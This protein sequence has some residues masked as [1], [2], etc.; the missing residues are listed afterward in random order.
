[1]FLVPQVIAEYWRVVTS[2][3]SQRGGFGWDVKKTDQSVQRLE[4]T[5]RL[6]PDIPALYGQWRQIVLAVGVTGASVYDARLI[7]AMV[8]H[9]LTHILTLLEVVEEIEERWDEEWLCELDKSWDGIYRS[10]TDGELEYDNG[11]YPLN[12]AI[13][14]GQQLYDGDDYII[15]YVEPAKVGDVALALQGIS[16]DNLRTQ[17]WKINSKNYGSSPGTND[18]E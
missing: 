2:V 9:K 10:L 6:Q 5:F 1:V 16:D 12:H 11:L 17:Y 3:D 18:R 8:V 7:A 4:Q 13:L 14:G 15:A